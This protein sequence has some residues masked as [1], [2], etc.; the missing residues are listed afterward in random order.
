MGDEFDPYSEEYDNPLSKVLIPLE[1]SDNIP[2][3]YQTDKKIRAFSPIVPTSFLPI[4]AS[5]A[6][7]SFRFL[8]LEPP[9]FSP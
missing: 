6:P 3:H 2:P 7:L 9:F 1:K 5:P 8:P 4:L